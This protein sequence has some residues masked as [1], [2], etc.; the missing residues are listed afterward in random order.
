MG[1][2]VEFFYGIESRYSYLAA[3]QMG[4]LERDTAATVTWRPLDLDDLM[5]RRG[6]DPFAGSPPS[7]QYDRDYRTKDVARWA[8]YYGI[9]FRNPDWS[10]LDWRR[11]SLAA[12]AADQ[13]GNARGFTMN[14]FNGVFGNGSPPTDDTVIARIAEITGFTGE[15][16]ISQIDDPETARRHERN[17]AD[18]LAVGVFGVPSFVVDGEAF[19]GNDRLILLRHHLG[20]KA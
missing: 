20:A 15:E 12:V 4:R 8:H 10:A 9:P 16:F 2:T 6:M 17:I 18:A 7:G 14:L 19:W 5:R 13:L 11:L 3:T 1:K